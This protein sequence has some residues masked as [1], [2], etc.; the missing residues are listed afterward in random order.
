MNYVR[1]FYYKNRRIRMTE[2]SGEYWW[3]LKDICDVLEVSS[4]GNAAPWLDLYEITKI[5]VVDSRDRIQNMYAVNISGIFSVIHK[6]NRP[7]ASSFQKWVATEM[8][9]ELQNTEESGIVTPGKIAVMQERLLDEMHQRITRLEEKVDAKAEPVQTMD[10]APVQSGWKERMNSYIDNMCK[11]YNLNRQ[12]IRHSLYNELE[13]TAGVDL[14][15]RQK[16]LQERMKRN[17][18]L[19]REASAVS[20][21]DV[22]ERDKMLRSIFEGLVEKAVYS[23]GGEGKVAL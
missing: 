22:I 9:P 4:A 20:K 14:T 7:E 1:K 21:I 8:L 15:R 11:E 13:L 16:N 19:Y 2:Q 6:C 18:A 10:P 5:G 3:V 17:G 12:K 23:S